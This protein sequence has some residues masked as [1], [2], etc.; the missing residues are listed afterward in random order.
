M[1]TEIIAGTPPRQKY[2][3][4]KVARA[5][6]PQ[7]ITPFQRSRLPSYEWW[8]KTY[9]GVPYLRHLSMGGADP[10]MEDVWRTPNR[11]E[12]MANSQTVVYTWLGC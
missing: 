7:E 11:Y 1:N 6:E 4:A 10:S 9:P 8:S 12:R 2:V 5:A 3:H